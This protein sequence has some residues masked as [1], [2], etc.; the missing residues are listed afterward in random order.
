MSGVPAE[1]RQHAR[2]CA[3]LAEHHTTPKA[4]QTFLDLSETWL[5]REQDCAQGF[6]DVLIGTETNRPNSFQ[7]SEAA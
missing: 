3:E 5:S 7:L 1:C 4:R 2:E 6:L